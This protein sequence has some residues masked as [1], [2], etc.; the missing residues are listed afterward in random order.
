MILCNTALALE[1]PQSCTESSISP[2]A[3]VIVYNFP[4]MH[5]MIFMLIAVLISCIAIV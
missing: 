1:L 3:F 2:F 5:R 4:V